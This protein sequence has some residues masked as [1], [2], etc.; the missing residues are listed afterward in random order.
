MNVAG[1]SPTDT[2]VSYSG[3]VWMGQ[4][5]GTLEAHGLYLVLLVGGVLWGLLQGLSAR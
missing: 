3:L 4:L 1:F 5:L 2:I